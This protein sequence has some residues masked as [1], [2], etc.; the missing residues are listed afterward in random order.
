M[1]YCT[2]T[3]GGYWKEIL[4][5]FWRNTYSCVDYRGK[6]ALY[7]GERLQDTSAIT[8]QETYASS[9]NAEPPLRHHTPLSVLS[10]STVN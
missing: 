8:L 4:M 6:Y 7:F 3:G 5:I 1:T 2:G 9:L 10:N